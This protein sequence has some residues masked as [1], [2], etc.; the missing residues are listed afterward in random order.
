MMI[1]INIHKTKILKFLLIEYKKELLLNSL[2]IGLKR[3][4]YCQGIMNLR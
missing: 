3:E 2:C 4:K 1:K